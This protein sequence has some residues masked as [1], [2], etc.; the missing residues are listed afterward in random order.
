MPDRYLNLGTRVRINAWGSYI[1][2][3]TA[4]T[5][6]LGLYLNNPGSTILTTPAVLTLG[7]AVTAV[8]RRCRGS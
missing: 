5:M 1:A 3:T 7:P 6:A 8:G 2:T 4:S